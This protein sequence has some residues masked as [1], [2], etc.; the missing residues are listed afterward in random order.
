[1]VVVVWGGR[2]EEMMTRIVVGYLFSPGVT[3]KF[4]SQD[5]HQYPIF[6]L[7]FSSFFLRF[8]LFFFLFPHCTA[9]AAAAAMNAT[10]AAVTCKMMVFSLRGGSFY[11]L[12]APR[13]PTPS[14]PPSVR[15]DPSC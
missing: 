10:A 2:R 15:A 3:F 5:S 7:L 11:G 4:V 13:H 14:T 8:L 12:P 9:A 1:M 6:L